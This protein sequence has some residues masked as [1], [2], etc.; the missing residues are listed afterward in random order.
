MEERNISKHRSPNG[1]LGWLELLLGYLTTAAL[2]YF[3]YSVLLQDRV[4][5]TVLSLLA[6]TFQ[7]SLITLRKRPISI[8]LG[9]GLKESKVAI[10]WNQ[11]KGETVFPES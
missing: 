3:A 5:A 4:A 11:N 2:L 6:V 1:F 7:I 9:I 10:R 8:N